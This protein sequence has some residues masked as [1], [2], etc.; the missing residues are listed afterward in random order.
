MI[1]FVDHKSNYVRVFF[2]KT[3]DQ[4]AK[5]V[6]HFLATDSG[7]E[8]ENED[9]FCKS[10]CVA[11][12]RNEANNQA[13]NGM[14][15]RMHRTVVNMARCMIFACGLSLSFWENAVQYAAY[16]LNRAPTNTNTGRMSPLKV[17]TKQTP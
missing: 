13:S 3:K 7:G 12:Q 5:N 10:T 2:T 4:A 17:L 8:Y 15:E 16:I 14:S 9:M 6:E 11:R 1:N